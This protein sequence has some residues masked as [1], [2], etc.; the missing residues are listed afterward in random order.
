M[1][2][3]IE[4]L[5][6]SKKIRNSFINILCDAKEENMSYIGQNQIPD[7]L[8]RINTYYQ[9]FVSDYA[10]KYISDNN[11]DF[12]YQ[13][14]IDDV[15]LTSINEQIKD[16][17]EIANNLKLRYS[18]CIEFNMLVNI[19]HIVIELYH[20]ANN[21]NTKLFYYG[22]NLDSLLSL[23]TEKTQ[24]QYLK[25]INDFKATSPY[26]VDCIKYL[27][28]TNNEDRNA[29]LYEMQTEDLLFFNIISDANNKSEY[30]DVLIIYD[31]L[32]KNHELDKE[33]I[34]RYLYTVIDSVE[35]K[36]PI[37]STFKNIIFIV[38]IALTI[39]AFFFA[40]NES[41]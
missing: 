20:E 41:S 21:I 12:D 1:T 38:L 35:S 36:P 3:E 19:H 22:E 33:P 34:T 31:L 32:N 5:Q 17:Q 28:V 14:N 6:L 4:A 18:F 13:K 8:F 24:N 15:Y 40:F 10:S 30:R 23:G 11:L 27:N 9:K 26:D 29:L 2:K 39:L 37:N 16:F 7:Y 25:I